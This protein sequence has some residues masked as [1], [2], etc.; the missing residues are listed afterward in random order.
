MI[1]ARAQFCGRWFPFGGA[2]MRLSESVE[3]PAPRKRAARD[4]YARVA[5]GQ[6]YRFFRHLPQSLRP[7]GATGTSEFEL[8]VSKDR[9]AKA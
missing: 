1:Q 9:K 8:G 5:T 6:D 7:P 3:V 4:H 2:G